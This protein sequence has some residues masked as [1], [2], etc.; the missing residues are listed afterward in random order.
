MFTPDGTSCAP[1]VSPPGEGAMFSR[2]HQPTAQILTEDLRNTLAMARDEAIA[3]QHD[4][5]GT[6][7]VLL[8]LLRA[9][10]IGGILQSFQ[11]TPEDLCAEIA[12]RIYPGDSRG[13]S[14][15]LPYTS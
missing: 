12:T 13:A 8:A 7:H 1:H 15:D 2:K 3:L 11:L 14:K 4:Y 6:E 9:S 5:I 10:D